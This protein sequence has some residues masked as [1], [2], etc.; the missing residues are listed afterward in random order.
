M[1]LLSFSGLSQTF[2]AFDVFSGLSANLP[3]DGKVGLV[4]PNGIGKTSL[5]LILAGLA[6][7]AR[8]SVHLARGRRIGY[9]RQEAVEAFAERANTVYGEMLTVFAGLREQQERLHA[10][11]A[12]MTAGD[13]SA[14]TLERYGGEQEQFELAGGYDY[15]LRIQ[16]TLT[17]LGF[18]RG[19]WEQISLSTA[20][21]D[22]KE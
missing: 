10:L 6:A 14:E 12:A 17:G 3:N 20:T 7:P 15:D 21:T 9:L 13:H 11:E 22:V 2:G 18:V 8:G 19:E 5:L 16:Q 1:S 4:G